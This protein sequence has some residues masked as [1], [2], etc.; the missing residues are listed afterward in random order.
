MTTKTASLQPSVETGDRAEALDAELVLLRLQDV[1]AVL[2]ALNEGALLGD[3]PCGREARRRH[4]SAVV[5]IDLVGEKLERLRA[6]LE[7]LLPRS[8]PPQ[9]PPRVSC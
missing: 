1:L 7:S 5:L 8:S 9:D 4:Q 6:D 3:P 2:H